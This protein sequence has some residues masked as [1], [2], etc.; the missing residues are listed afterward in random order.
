[1]KKTTCCTTKKRSNRLFPAI[2]SLLSW[3]YYFTAPSIIVSLHSAADCFCI[4]GALT[5][6]CSISRMRFEVFFKTCKSYLH[7]VKEYRGLSFDAMCGHLA[8]VFTRYMILAINHRYSDDRLS[9]GEIFFFMVDEIADISFDDS[10][11]IIFTALFEAISVVFQPTEAKMTEFISTFLGGLPDYM[12]KV[13]SPH[14]RDYGCL[15]VYLTW[16]LY[17]VFKE[18]FHFYKWEV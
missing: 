2:S 13:L 12:Q 11:Q 17:R 15:I 14:T 3:S 16:H 7:L 1:M 6:Y 10:M 5:V 18:L 4:E 8:V 9:L